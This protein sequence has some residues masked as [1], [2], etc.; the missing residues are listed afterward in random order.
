MNVLYTVILVDDQPLCLKGMESGFDW[1]KYG[2][3]VAYKTTS[4]KVALEMIRELDPDVVCTDMRMPCISGM[5]LIKAAKAMNAK[6][7][8]IIVSG[9]EDFEK[10]CEAIQYNVFRYCLKPIDKRST[11][12]ILAELKAALDSQ[13]QRWEQPERAAEACPANDVHNHKFRKLLLYME[14]HYMDALS[15]DELAK[16]FEINASFA[17]RLFSQYFEM[18]YSQYLTTL[19]LKNATDLLKNTKIPIEEVSYVVGFNDPA[20]FSRTFKKYYGETP[21]AYRCRES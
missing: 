15:L 14:Q 3:E 19:R 20:Y 10:A 2:F 4:P 1:K 11:E 12:S 17:S 6:A 16:K 8:F 7:K 5:E 9:Y 21:Y 13:N 18:G